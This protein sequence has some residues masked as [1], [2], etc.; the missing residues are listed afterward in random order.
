VF[1][2]VLTALRRLAQEHH[3]AA[4]FTT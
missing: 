3:S 1:E 4:R 2:A